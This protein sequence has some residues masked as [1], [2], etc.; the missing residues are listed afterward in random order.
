MNLFLLCLPVTAQAFEGAELKINGDL[1]SFFVAGFPEEHLLQPSSNYGQAFLDGRLKIK[2][3]ITDQI[4]V[5]AHHAITFGTAP[6]ITALE[7]ELLTM[8]VESDESPT[9]MMTGVG[10]QAPEVIDL[11]WKGEEGDLFLQGRTD[12]LFA[13]ASLGPVDFRLGRQPISFGHGF[14]FNP[15]DLVQPF[16]FATIDS[17]YKPGIDSFRVDAYLGMST[18]ITGL[19]AYA[20]EWEKEGMIAIVNGNTTLGWTDISLFYG[21]VK[22][23]NVIGTGTA[24]SI[25]PVGLHGDVT[26]TIPEEEDIFVRAVA[27]WMWKPLEN[28]TL[29]GEFY[30]QTVGAENNDGYVEF[31]TSDRY[32]RGELWLMGKYYASIAMSQQIT[33]LVTGNISVIGNL[34]DSSAMITPSI[35]VSVSNEV[36]LVAGGYAGIG[37]QPEDIELIDLLLEEEYVL[38]SEFGMMPKSMFLQLKAYF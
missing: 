3:Q 28:S 24:S 38:P 8:G 14:M 6:P 23:D 4:Y 20:G 13:Q 7:E 5:D 18:Q 12:R 25:G 37:E 1:K 34:A 22:G 33:S 19:V 36:Q 31:I 30:L 11:S 16:S 15:M 35:Q 2:W 27:G 26:V 21:L 32:A 10:L 9:V 17:E 29:N